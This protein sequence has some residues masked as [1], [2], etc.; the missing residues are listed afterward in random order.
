MLEQ[1]VGNEESNAQNRESINS[2]I[3]ELC[4]ETQAK[5]RFGRRHKC[6]TTCYRW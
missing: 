6:Y 2:G 5:R 3:K 4:G 1:I